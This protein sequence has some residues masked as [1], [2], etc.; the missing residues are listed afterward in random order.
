MPARPPTAVYE[1]LR[2]GGGSSERCSVPAEIISRP[3]CS[4]T[5]SS[6]R[7]SARRRTGKTREMNRPGVA[8]GDGRGR[9]QALPP[10][11]S[12]ANRSAYRDARRED[13][14]CRC[15]RPWGGAANFDD[16][17]KDGTRATA[18]EPV[19]GSVAPSRRV[20]RSRLR[21]RAWDARSP[22]SRIAPAVTIHFVD[23]AHSPR[24]PRADP[25]MR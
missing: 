12:G 4:S 20:V 22:R 15:T 16:P 2:S 7:T 13:R 24:D 6:S 10:R 9:D 5:G 14:E 19:D 18:T 8:T 1:R 17:G 25:E 21:C 23:A 3:W 11:A